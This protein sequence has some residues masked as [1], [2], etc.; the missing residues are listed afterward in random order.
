MK[1]L[2]KKI[3]TLV[4]ATVAVT[5]SATTAFAAEDSEVVF[6]YDGGK[7]SFSV[8]PGSVYSASD[9]FV[10]FKELMPGDSV[11]Q[12]I[13]LKYDGKDG[14]TARIYIK[15]LGTAVDFPNTG[16]GEALSGKTLNNKVL[17]QLELDVT[18]RKD[19][20]KIF[21]ATAEKTDGMTDWV[22]LGNL[23]RGGKAELD[24]T[25][26]VPITMGNEFAGVAAGIDW[27]FKVE[28][29][30]DTTPPGP[31]D[32]GDNTNILLFGGIAGISGASIILLLLLKKKSEDEQSENNNR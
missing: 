9:L 20:R 8:T 31:P 30:P 13:T 5:L 27:L 6:S 26:N 4:V 29:I 28:E 10:N 22:H 32:T 16:D 19:N 15:S 25:I 12:S 2:L 7:K 3:F 1:K 14:Y 18:V 23:R 24:V 21:D 11:T 17:E